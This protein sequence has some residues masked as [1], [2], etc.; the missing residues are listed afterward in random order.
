MSSATA[1]ISV[2][3]PENYLFAQERL[4]FLSDKF[5]IDIGIPLADVFQETDIASLP[6]L[7]LLDLVSE[8]W[9]SYP[10]HSW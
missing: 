3:F 7:N 1:S 10:T 9:M 4:D 8:I 2:T 6:L 5:P